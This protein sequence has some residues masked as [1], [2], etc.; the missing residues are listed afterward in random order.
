[1]RRHLDIRAPAAALAD[2]LGVSAMGL[3]R[4]FRDSTGLSPGRAFLE[5]KM[6]EAQRLLRQENATVKETALALGYRHL[7]DF[8][9]AYTRFHGQSPSQQSSSGS[10]GAVC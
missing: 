8:T 1:M 2:Y 9:R 10:D 5:I 4:L 6:R 7:G 3:H